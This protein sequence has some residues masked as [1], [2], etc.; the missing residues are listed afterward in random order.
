MKRS[1]SLS[2][3]LVAA[4]AVFV[5]LAPAASAGHLVSRLV[6]WHEVG[7]I[8]LTDTTFMTDE[9][10]TTRTEWVETSDW[11]WAAI[12]AQG[13]V[14]SG[15]QICDVNF[16]CS[17]A[18][19]GVTDSLYFLPEWGA[20]GQEVRIGSTVANN[21]KPDTMFVINTT[22]AA[23]KGCVAQSY[24]A[25][26]NANVWTGALMLDQDGQTANTA[27]APIRRFRLRVSGDQG[28]TSPK[29]SGLFCLITYLKRD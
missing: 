14:A 25:S 18:N 29:L 7:A 23:V 19:N 16:V 2:V 10:D 4:L 9:A 5:S 17:R 26:P 6:R 27:A 11:D 3:V 13:S 28:G 22:L 12:M 15:W 21:L 20:A 24:I 8:A 1:F